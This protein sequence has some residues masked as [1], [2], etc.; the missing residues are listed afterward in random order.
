MPAVIDTNSL[1]AWR[2]SNDELHTKGKDIVEAASDGQLPKI[3][4]PHV[5]FQE[6]CKHVHNE[7]GNQPCIDTMNALT[8]DPQFTIITLTDGD[9]R[10]GRALF[11][12]SLLE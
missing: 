7:L 12:K 5:F 1:Y 10:R 8:T 2:N 11:N 9:L 6:T 4:I 3:Y